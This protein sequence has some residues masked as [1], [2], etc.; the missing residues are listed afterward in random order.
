MRTASIVALAS[1]TLLVTSCSSNEDE[2]S[3]AG[4]STTTTTVPDRSDEA[5]STTTVFAAGDDGYANFRIPAIVTA[6]NGDLLAFA[7]GR[8]GSAADDGNVDLGL[9]RSTDDGATWGPLQVVADAGE[10]FIGNPAPVVDPATGRLVVLA[11]AKDGDDTEVEILTGTGDSTNRPLLLTSDDDGET[12]T[13]PV[14]ISDQAKQPEWRWYST[15]PG[16]AIA[17]QGPEHEG[18]LVVA[19]NHSHPRD[20]FGAHAIFSDDGGETWSIGGVDTPELGSPRHPDES[21][22]VE[23]ADGTLLFASRDQGGEDQWHRLQTTSSDG[24]ESFDQPYADQVGLVA[25]IV[26]AS[27]LRIEPDGGPDG[28]ILVFSSPSDDEDRVDLRL[29]T[30]TDD[31]ATWDDGHLVAE[32]PAAY[33][34]LVSLPGDALGVLHEGGDDGPYDRINF[35]TLGYGRISGG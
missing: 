23:L 8:V 9:K 31:G 28:G 19:A 6:A 15:G 33:S 29:R 35:T 32:G 20:G 22:A 4:A 10:D 3:P 27:I 13:D 7:E 30:S 5:P 2:G 14:D 11:L 21:M 1:I 17:L 16:H 25:P 26:Q 24:G 18:R 12:W 34:D